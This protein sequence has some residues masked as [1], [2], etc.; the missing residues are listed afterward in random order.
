MSEREAGVGSSEDSA[1]IKDAFEEIA[2]LTRKGI[3]ASA[4]ALQRGYRS[5]LRGDMGVAFDPKNSPAL[6]FGAGVGAGLGLG[7]ALL[8]RMSPAGRIASVVAGAAGGA[9][10]ASAKLPE[11]APEPEGGEEPGS[12]PSSG[13]IPRPV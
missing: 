4:R 10:L 7:A 3:L 11:E 13:R 5:M 9:L 12:A 8:F 2:G 6:A 1:E